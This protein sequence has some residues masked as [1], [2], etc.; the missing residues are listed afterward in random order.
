M[1]ICMLIFVWTCLHFSWYICL[2]MYIYRSGNSVFN[3]LR[4]CQTF[5]KQLHHFLFLP[6]VNESSNFSISSLTLGWSFCYSHPS[7]D[8]SWFWFAFSQMAYDS[9]FS[10]G[11]LYFFEECLFRFFGLF[12]ISLFV[13]EF[14]GFFVYILNSSS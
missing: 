6:V 14:Q 1:N 13:F 8:I 3:H 9:I 12:L 7:S 4:N 11:C 2:Y 10:C 5:P